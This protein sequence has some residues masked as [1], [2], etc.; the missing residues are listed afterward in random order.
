MIQTL[1]ISGYRSLR[2]LV[3]P[4]D[5]LTLV[6]GANGTGKSSPLSRAASPRRRGPQLRC[7]VARSR[8]RPAIH[9]VGWPGD[10]R[11]RRQTRRL[12]V[13]HHRAPE[14]RQPQAR[15]RRRS[16]Q[17]FDRPRLSPRR[18]R[19]YHSSISIPRSS[20][21]RVRRR[22][23]RTAVDTG[24]S[25]QR[26]RRAC[27]LNPAKLRRPSHHATSLDRQHARHHRR[28][29]ARSRTA[30]CPR[31]HPRLA[32]LRR[33]PHRHRLARP[34]PADRHPHRRAHQ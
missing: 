27:R 8:R 32:L 28:S 5:R 21:R 11:P 33:L 23:I 16:L 15:L 9:A 6:T 7:R 10:H 2:D 12:A 25:P 31:V 14:T 26:S 19:P 18:H 3:L 4:L 34:H 29:R 17:L 20:A 24:R 1:A 22:G 13:E 30:R